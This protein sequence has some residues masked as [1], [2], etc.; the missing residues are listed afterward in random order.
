MNPSVTSNNGPIF[1]VGAP[2]SGTT[3]LQYMMRSHPRLSLPT[4]ESHFFIPLY[5]NAEQFGDLT[6]I[7]NIRAILESMYRQSAE[8]LDTDLHGIK[9]DIAA[10]AEEFHREN[11]STMP[12]IISGLF[13]K[14][15]RGEGKVRWGDKT[16]YYVLHI[17][18]LMEWFP[19]AQIIHLIRDGRDC[20]LSLF[21]RKHDF[22]V[23]NVYH[24][25]KYWQ[26]YVEVGCETGR[27]YGPDRYMEVRY[28]DLLGDQTA[29][30]HKI[31]DFLREDFTDALV[32]YKKAGQA[33]KTPLL[34]K[35]LQKDNSEKWRSKMSPRQI[36]IFESAAGDT[37]QHHGYELMTSAKR[38]FLPIR[39]LFRLHN[40]VISW[41]NRT[42]HWSFTPMLPIIIL[43]NCL[44]V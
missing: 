24:A 26:Q 21:A 6:R 29:V 17:P 27:Q 44:A 7:E 28:E 38:L 5:R 16:P 10:L 13:E 11:R 34:Q 2:R 8:F 30:M 37:L 22:G 23:Y 18:K 43:L 42:R 36:R 9:F 39:I 4:G 3:L 19:N 1:I 32:N 41:L 12:A 20:A 14:N 31:C 25:A 40:S 33:G 35:S 15:A